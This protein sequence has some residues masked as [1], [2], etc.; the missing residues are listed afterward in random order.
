[1]SVDDTWIGNRLANS[2]D[3]VTLLDSTGSQVDK[4]VFSDACGRAAGTI[5]DNSGADGGGFTLERDDPF[6]A[7][8]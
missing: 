4:V 3:E 2:G 7:G 8:D 6:G 1:M 5:D